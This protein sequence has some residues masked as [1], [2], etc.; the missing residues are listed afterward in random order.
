MMQKEEI[1][2][3]G[4][5]LTVEKYISEGKMNRVIIK[6]DRKNYLIDLPLNSCASRSFL[7]AA[8]SL[9]KSFSFVLHNFDVSVV[10]VTTEN[11]V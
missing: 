1:N 10:K 9:V 11:F 5:F 2:N 6:T 7:I 8:I 3:R 4:T